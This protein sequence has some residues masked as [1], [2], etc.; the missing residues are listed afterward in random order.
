MRPF[1]D[2]APPHSSSRAHPDS[3][4][5]SAPLAG[6]A[7]RRG[8]RLGPPEETLRPRRVR[9]EARGGADS[10][11]RGDPAPTEGRGRGRAD[12]DADPAEETLL[13][14]RVG[15]RPAEAQTRTPHPGDLAPTEGRG[16]GEARGAAADAELAAAPAP[17]PPPSSDSA[18]EV[19]RSFG[20]VCL[21][22]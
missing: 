19:R 5:V 10:D 18:P 17:A 20:C 16:G 6:P 8:R 14:R 15:A 7:C 4:A 2:C 13:P 12:A 21:I 1:Q 11:P 9:G 3:S 22:K